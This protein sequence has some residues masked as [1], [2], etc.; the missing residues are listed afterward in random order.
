MWMMPGRHTAIG[1]QKSTEAT[2]AL[3]AV[4][5]LKTL[6]RIANGIKI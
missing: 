4:G 1:G 2:A 6:K 3:S 5:I